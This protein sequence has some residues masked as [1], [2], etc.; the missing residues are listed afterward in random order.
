MHLFG[1]TALLGGSFDPPHVG[2]M[3]VCLYLLE[4]L[5]AQEVWMIPA[6]QHALGKNLTDFQQRKHMCDLLAA[7]F[8]GRVVVKT[9]EYGTKSSGYT[10]DT[11]QLLQQRYQTHKFVLVIGEDI[12]T[13]KHLWHR[14]SDIERLVP[15]IVLGRQGFNEPGAPPLKLP[16]IRSHVLRAQ[17]QL[18]N[19]IFGLVP[20]A[21]ADYIKIAKLYQ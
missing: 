17:V 10:F 16:D 11:I 9:V 1:Y 7:P 15:V 5:A 13:E 20:Q 18:G 14:F 4:A 3:M 19:S 21:I 6:H 12:L 8:G 2:H